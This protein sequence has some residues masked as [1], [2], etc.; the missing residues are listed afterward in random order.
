[1]DSCLCVQATG[2]RLGTVV[3]SMVSIIIALVIGFIYS[4]HMTLLILGFVPVLIIAG[5]LQMDQFT[6]KSNDN[7]EALEKAGKV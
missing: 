5:I 4:W 7:Q 3:Q 6:N 1:M 2:A